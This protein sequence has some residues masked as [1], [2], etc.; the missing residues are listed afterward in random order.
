MK[1]FLLSVL[2]T[3]IVGPASGQRHDAGPDESVRATISTGVEA[4]P[5]FSLPVASP[6]VPFQGRIASSRFWF[7]P[8]VGW[9]VSTR[10][11]G[12]TD[13]IENTGFGVFEQVDPTVSL[14]LGIGVDLGSGVGLRVSADLAL[15]ASV[16]GEWRC[17]P[18]VACPAVLLPLD[19]DLT[20]WNGA[21][22]ALYTIPIGFRLR[23]VAF[24]G[25]GVRRAGLEWNEPAA[26]VTLPAFSFDDTEA[27]YR[28]GAGAVYSLGAAAEIFG[29]VEATATRFGGGAYDSIEGSVEAD[30]KLSFDMGF[31]VGVRVR[32]PV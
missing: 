27:I 8:R 25:V 6:S 30:R 3:F 4:G 24:A 26:D 29:Q 10:D 22:E 18:F 11:L 21:V 9:M 19:G 23:P 2:C 32:V 1:L 17:A 28:L 7:E 14:G 15:A 12:R 13:V 16:H 5:R 31:L 20:R